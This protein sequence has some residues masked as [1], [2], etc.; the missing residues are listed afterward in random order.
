MPRRAAE[1]SLLQALTFGDSPK[2]PANARQGGPM[3]SPPSTQIRAKPVRPALQTS[4][5]VFAPLG[6]AWQ[7]CFCRARAHVALLWLSGRGSRTSRTPAG[8]EL[9]LGT[10]H[11]GFLHGCFIPNLHLLY[12]AAAAAT[13]AHLGALCWVLPL[14]QLK[15]L[16]VPSAAHRCNIESSR[17]EPP[18]PSD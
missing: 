11:W 4:Q 5:I 16:Q 17:D 8:T 2:Q 13:R 15:Q 18:P 12:P 6:L 10:C 3:S 1:S 9:R 14:P 7:P